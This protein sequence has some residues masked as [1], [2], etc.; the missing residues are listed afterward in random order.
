MQARAQPHRPNGSNT[1]YRVV[2]A[3]RQQAGAD[4][5]G[6][7]TPVPAGGALP[8]APRV[9]R[10]EELRALA[11]AQDK[12]VTLFGYPLFKRKVERYKSVLELVTR[13]HAAAALPRAHPRDRS[14]INELD[15]AAEALAAKVAA[16][17]VG[18][19]GPCKQELE[20]VQHAL[21]RVS[22]PAQTE[23]RAPL[24][25]KGS[26]AVTPAGGRTGAALHVTPMAGATEHI[27]K[28]EVRAS[29]IG[30]A[31][32][33]AGITG[34]WSDRAVA[35][36][37]LAEALGLG[38]LVPRTEAVESK[39]GKSL[40]MA[41]APGMPPQAIGS[42]RVRL[43]AD[44]NDRLRLRPDLLAD[45]VAER[46]Y[47]G[48]EHDAA[49]GV[50]MLHNL[51]KNARVRMGGNGK[52]VVNLRGEPVREDLRGPIFTRIDY[53]RGDVRRGITE[54]QWLDAMSG[55]MDRTGAN[56]HLAIADD[57]ALTSVSAFDNETGFSPLID[58]A[59][60]GVGLALSAQ[61]P[62]SPRVSHRAH[63]PRAIG[64]TLKRTIED[65]DPDILDTLLRDL[66]TQA[67]KLLARDVANRLQ[68][69][70][71]AAL[72][73]DKEWE[74]DAVAQALGLL[75]FDAEFDRV[76]AQAR[77]APAGTQT[78]ALMRGLRAVC[79]TAHDTSY[80][81]R[82]AANLA[83]QDWL[84]THGKDWPGAPPAAPV[85]SHD[86]LLA[87]LDANAGKP[88]RLRRGALTPG[89]GSDQGSSA[90]PILPT[91]TPARPAR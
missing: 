10:C 35:T 71:A 59:D 14:R 76:A 23:A 44:L 5:G 75:D 43:P 33:R 6:G 19:T 15:R 41:V 54:L 83:L 29:R 47:T 18:A 49:Q 2:D 57:G 45:Y 25:R 46:G 40:V 90:S 88:R 77:Q 9:P 31:A 73:D 34:R 89:G 3:A 61:D 72:R 17:L 38:H 79:N 24:E 68:D 60:A 64:D 13:Y 30:E 32:R 63:M 11:M 84:A 26:P 70:K 36:A 91:M 62:D 56:F 22:M 4:A 55:E 67:S 86:D 81:A 58:S 42:L 12:D 16:K 82:E 27:V 28:H 87:Y 66:P 74:D 53:R 1:H 50:L 48:H 7:G 37:K 51:H 65:F 78:Q 69:G 80:V 85:Y 21:D 20:Q 39:S 8:P 52:P